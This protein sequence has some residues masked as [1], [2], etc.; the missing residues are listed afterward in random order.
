LVGR[1]LLAIP[2]VLIK[3]EFG[4][5]RL[6]DVS[7]NRISELDDGVFRA[8]IHLLVLNASKNNI[9]VVSGEIKNCK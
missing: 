9:E 7:R 6:L 4:R 2:G 3:P 8:A 5:I 1:E